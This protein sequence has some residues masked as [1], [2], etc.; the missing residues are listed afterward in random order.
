LCLVPF[1]RFF[2]PFGPHGIARCCCCASPGL[3]KRLFHSWVKIGSS[4]CNV[5]CLFSSFIHAGI[6]VGGGSSEPHCVRVEL[7]LS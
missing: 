3:A 2:L 5:S 7:E 1:L 4:S 6:N